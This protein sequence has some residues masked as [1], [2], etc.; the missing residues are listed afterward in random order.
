M[1]YDN[2]TNLLCGQAQL[3]QMM[4]MGS[5]VAALWGDGTGQQ[6]EPPA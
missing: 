6:E 2:E 3:L 4:H 1:N 5:H